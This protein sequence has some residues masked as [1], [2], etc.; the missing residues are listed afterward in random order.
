MNNIEQILDY[1]AQRLHDYYQLYPENFN[2]L[3]YYADD[4]EE[5]AAAEMD[6]LHIPHKE[7]VKL[8]SK[9]AF[10]RAIFDEGVPADESFDL[11]RSTFQMKPEVFRWIPA[12]L[13]IYDVHVENKDNLSYNK[14]AVVK[15]PIVEDRVRGIIHMLGL[16][17]LPGIIPPPPMPRIRVARVPLTR[18]NNLYAN[19]NSNNNS[20]KSRK[21]NANKMNNIRG[22]HPL[23][24]M[25]VNRFAKSKRNGKRSK[26]GTRSIRL[27]PQY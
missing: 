8:V 2:K 9:S 10:F 14:N 3:F 4:A 19:N 6:I 17:L 1:S 16:P 7:L 27:T 25:Y 23:E 5:H 22:L 15:R 21:S 12:V 24:A 26:K 11:H 13:A 20:T 18:R